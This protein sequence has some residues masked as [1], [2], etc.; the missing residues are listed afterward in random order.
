MGL[1]FK[2]LGMLGG[3]GHMLG[4]TTTEAE[5]LV[6]ADAHIDHEVITQ[7][8]ENR[9]LLDLGFRALRI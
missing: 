7:S 2:V 9:M 4:E 6:E 8:L 3:L 1:A 5:H